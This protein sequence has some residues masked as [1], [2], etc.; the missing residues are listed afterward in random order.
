MKACVATGSDPTNPEKF[1]AYMVPS[2]DEVR[3]Y[4]IQSPKYYTCIS[5][6]QF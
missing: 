2:P 4:F 5:A 1:L 3:L 6:L